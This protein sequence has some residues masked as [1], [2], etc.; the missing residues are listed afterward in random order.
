MWKELGRGEYDQ[1][2]LDKIAK[3]TDTY[4]KKKTHINIHL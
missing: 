1:N 2:T 3:E 4:E